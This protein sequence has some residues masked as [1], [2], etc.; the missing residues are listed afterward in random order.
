MNGIEK[1]QIRLTCVD[2]AIKIKSLN[3]VLYKNKTVLDIAKDLE[4][5]ILNKNSSK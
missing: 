1:A 4:D 2:S 3:N 5:F